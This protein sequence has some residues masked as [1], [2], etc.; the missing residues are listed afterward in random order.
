MSLFTKIIRYFKE[1]KIETKKV[2]WP[3]RKETFQYTLL[4]IIISLGV[5]AFLGFL[6]YLLS[7]GIEKLIRKF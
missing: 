6:D 4:V 2:V 3:S 1:A 7:Q 5:A